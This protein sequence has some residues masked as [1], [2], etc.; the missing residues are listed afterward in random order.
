MDRLIYHINNNRVNSGKLAVY[1]LGQA[2]FVFKT[3]RGTKIGVDLYLSDCCNRYFG[4]KRLMPMLVEPQ[5][6]ELELL[7]ATHAHYDHFDVDT[8]PLLLNGHTKFI[9][10]RDC[11]IEC[12]R[13]KIDP[14]Q[15]QFIAPGEIAQYLD[16][17]I[18]AQKCNHGVGAPDAI[19]LLLEISGK[20]VY[21]TGD[22]AFSPEYLTKE[23]FNP[24]LLILPI[25][26]AFGN[27]D[28]IQATQYVKLLQP[29]LVIPC[30]YWN[31]A[32]HGGNPYIFMEHM[33]ESVPDIVY[34]IM[35][36]GE[37]IVV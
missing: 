4:F 3:E 37:N 23:L 1:W 29:K 21:I 27:L 33:K 31:F 19:G 22:T 20:K 30:H 24:D 26:G 15:T 36:M 12:E 10:A 34:Q 18:T 16:V 8:I 7:I 9:G 6:L 32:E 25:N 14:A 2:G 5:E 11:K 35:R 28:E 17:G 13:L